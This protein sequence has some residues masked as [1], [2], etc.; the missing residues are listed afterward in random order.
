M[1]IEKKKKGERKQRLDARGQRICPFSKS[2]SN[3][4]E[5]KKKSCGRKRKGRDVSQSG[6]KRAHWGGDSRLL[7]GSKMV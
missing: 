7:G 5:W 6:L 2:R 3:V 4:G 1:Q